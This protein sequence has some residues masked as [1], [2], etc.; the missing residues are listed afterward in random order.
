MSQATLPAN[1]HDRNVYGYLLALCASG[2]VRAI[3]GALRY[4][5]DEG[6]G[7]LRTDEYPYGLPTLSPADS[8]LVLGMPH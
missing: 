5:D 6:P 1:L 4:Q 8:E 7:V 3:L 2:R